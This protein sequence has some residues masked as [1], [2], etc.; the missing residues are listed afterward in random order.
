M[1]GSSA[2]VAGRRAALE[3]VRSGLAR[4]VLVAA[5]IQGTTGLREL[6][7]ACDSAGIRVRE[8]PRSELDRLAR[9]H[10][11][12]AV[13][14]RAP[15]ELAERDLSTWPFPED[16]VVVV[17]DGVTDPQNLGASARSAEA[18]GVS[19]LVSRVHRAAPVTPAAVRA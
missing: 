18:A 17:L 16:A 3:A 2:I 8:V 10:Q 6:R 12:V 14:I 7:V 19:M 5:G 9:D 4:E 11:G 13:R 1:S 15:R